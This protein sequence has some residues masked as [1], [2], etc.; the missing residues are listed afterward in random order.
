MTRPPGAET[1]DYVVVGAGATGS[2]VANRLSRDADTRVL[3][4]EAGGPDTDPRI[5]PVDALVQTWGSELDWALLTEPQPGMDGRQ[6]LINQGKVV[7]GSTSIHA[8]MWVRGHRSNFDAWRDG[9]GDG[10]GFDDVLEFFTTIE[11][12]DGGASRYRG[13]GGPVRVRT[14]PDPAARSDAF[15]RA[16]TELGY[17][18]PAWDYNGERQENGAGP[19]QFTIDDD[20]ARVSAASAYLHPVRERANLTI[21]TGAAAS[22]LIVEGSRVVGVEYRQAGEAKRV[23]AERE[24]IVSAGAFMSPKLLMLSG[25]GPAD[26]LRAHGIDVVLDLPGVGQNLQ[27]HLQLPVAF[28]SLVDAPSPGLLTGN[29]LF[30][31]TRRAS[32]TH[33]P[34]LQL[35]FTPSVPRPLAGVIDLGGPG[36]IFLPI[37]VQP[38]SVGEVRLRSADPD[39]APVIDP[40]YLSDEADV[41]V[42][43]EALRL[44]RELSGT[45]ALGAVVGPELAPGTDA[46]ESGYIRSQTA[47]L[48]HPAGTCRMGS[49]GDMGA[50]V[51]PELRVHG[52]ESLRVADASVMPRV[53]SGNTQ[54]ACFMIGEKLAHMML[55]AEDRDGATRRNPR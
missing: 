23:F 40:R 3:M 19:L 47:T 5:S 43:R 33:A 15:M 28:R 31:D 1:V 7:G 55:G 52:L 37:L 45:E 50:V 20:G 38:A 26:A 49:R 11:D 29:V 54:A 17:D 14:C 18:G 53:P 46:D 10:W 44:I 21:R 9:G 51:D 12:Y 8:M 16:A 32:G 2:V 34:D 22:R 27:D 48:W 41:A 6:I 30:V 36:C 39:D 4:L 42:F 24:V 35:N 25:I 13:A